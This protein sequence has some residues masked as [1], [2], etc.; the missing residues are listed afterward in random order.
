MTTSY[1]PIWRLAILATADTSTVNTWGTIQAQSM[2]LPEQGA[3]GV[4]SVNIGADTAYTL[5]TA[6]N[7]TDQARY[8]IQDYTGSLTA[9]CTVTIPNLSRI[10]WAQNS[11]TGGQNVTLTAGGTLATAVI[12]PNAAL[13]LWES[14]GMGGVSLPPVGFGNVVFPGSITLGTV[15]ISGLLTAATVDVTGTLTVGGGETITAGGLSVAGGATIDVLT[16]SGSASIADFLN[17]GTAGGITF[18]DTT[19]QVT[20]A[21]GGVAPSPSGLVISATSSTAI[22][23]TATALT[24]INSSGATKNLL[25]FSESIATGT[26][27]AG[28]LDT[29]SLAQAK[30][31]NVFA[32]YGTGG[33]AAM[34]SL[35]ATAP[36]LPSGYT[37]FS[38][39]GA[40]VTANGSA[41]LLGTLQKGRKAQYL[42][43]GANLSALPAIATGASGSVSA[44][45]W[46]AVNVTSGTQPLVP[47]TAA[48]IRVLLVNATG[49]TDTVMLAPNNSYGASGSISNPP[50]LVMDTS[51]A[52]K[53]MLGEFVLESVDVYY[54][55]T[56]GNTG[57]FVLGW[58][59]NL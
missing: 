41:V 30:V 33:T 44:P 26:A 27:G 31:Y 20:A 1:S 53:N 40:V 4:T 39:L 28:G 8:L 6:N 29:G 25:A 10:G 50:P 3:V 42:V 17:F 55:A 18:G 34:L 22:S 9:G 24:V 16:N 58:E 12:P 43:G 14:D 56:G 21:T 48:S 2:S 51:G 23:V 46:T 45:T 54:A 11:T 59:D 13:Y 52:P 57:A 7:A 37:Y 49:G 35:S 36:T 19:Q 38:R 32:I 47:P 5:T 15:T